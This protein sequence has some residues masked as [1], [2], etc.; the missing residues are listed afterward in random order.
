VLACFFVVVLVELA[1]EFLED[2]AH[3]VVV[4]AR[5]AEVDLGIEELVDQGAD[6]VGLG[7]G[8]ELIAELEV[9]EDV[10]DVG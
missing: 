10:L 1:D 9:L 5:R 2:R 7:E 4:D 8:L 6:G 3:G